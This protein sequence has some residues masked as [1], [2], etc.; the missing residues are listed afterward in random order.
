[1][2]LLNS[3]NKRTF[4]FLLSM[5]IIITSCS[6]EPGS[7][8]RASIKGY[9]HTTKYN[10]SFT[11]QQ[12]QYDGADEW[13]YIIYGD[14]ISYGDRIRSGPDGKFEFKYLR[15]GNYTIYVYSDDNTLQ[16]QHAVSKTVEI[17]KA[18][19]SLDAGTF[20]IDKN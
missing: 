16:G 10:S 19:E 4:P 11:I 17:K 20:E 9:V 15:K 13:V 12:G 6:K 3:I 5:F 7:G 8:G 14:D 2:L 18:T 1:M